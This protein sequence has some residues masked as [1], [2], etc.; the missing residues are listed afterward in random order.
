MECKLLIVD[1]KEYL[2]E[3]VSR[4]IDW[5]S[6][7]FKVF[8]ARDA[9]EALS[10]LRTEDI[11]I[12][13]TDVRMPKMDGLELTAKAKEINKEL[14][15]VVISGYA[16]F[17]LAQ[18][19][20]RLGVDDY[21]LKPFSSARLLEVVKSA[22]N[23]LQEKHRPPS[24]EQNGGQT[25]EDVF[26][27]LSTPEFFMHQSQTMDGKR[28]SEVLKTGTGEELNREISALQ[29]ALEQCFIHRKG[30]YI[31]LNSVVMSTLETVQQFGFS[32]DTVFE[33]IRA[34]IPPKTELS[35]EDLK[36][37]LKHYLTD[38]NTLIKRKQT[39]GIER[40]IQ[41]VKNYVDANYRFGV[42][43]TTLA[44]RFNVSASYLSKLFSDYVGENFSD[45]VRN[46]KLQRAKELLKTTDM[47]IYE[48][49]DYLGFNDA[50]YFSTWFS[51]S[52]GLSPTE[53]RESVSQD[54]RHCL[55]LWR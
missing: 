45:Y 2:R 17:E 25:I 19:S 26:E 9:Y 46:K 48:I 6:H 21:L 8:Q 13:V 53:Y 41:E 11:D 40:W 18:T 37:W 14:R 32:S 43:L 55:P 47:R 52:V 31:L 20:I 44:S 15:V 38:I 49:A 42:S 51:K 7:N 29:T 54:T 12:L 4:N 1:D 3:K 50:N 36:D 39:E 23:K 28:L 5:Q 34:H 27:W 35:V 10:I 30:V 33:L 16:E 22:R 24:P